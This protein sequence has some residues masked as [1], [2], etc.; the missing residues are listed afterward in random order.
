[1]LSL[2]GS[3]FFF[4]FFFGGERAETTTIR[5]WD[6]RRA[7]WTLIRVGLFFFSH[8]RRPASAVGNNDAS[9]HHRSLLYPTFSSACSRFLRFFSFLQFC[10]LVFV[11]FYFPFF[12]LSSRSQ[13]CSVWSSGPFLLFP[14]RPSVIEAAGFLIHETIVQESFQWDD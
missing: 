4:S 3:F 14:S 7:C 13:A 12:S 9:F 11:F 5:L 6:P 1:M 10:L 8:S 2:L